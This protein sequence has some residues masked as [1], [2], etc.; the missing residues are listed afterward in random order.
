[1]ASYRLLVKP[2]AVKELETLP[3]KDRRRIAGKIR[4]LASDPRPAGAEKLSGQEKNR[5]R[6]G[7][8]R[9][10]YSVDDADLSLV[11]VNIGHRRDVYR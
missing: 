11:V 10:L 2:S 6:Q 1:V 9:V 8:Y 5:L 3:V 7:N 4:K